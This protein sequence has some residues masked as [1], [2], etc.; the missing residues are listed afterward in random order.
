MSKALLD[1][2]KWAVEHLPPTFPSAEKKKAEDV[3][4]AFLANPKVS[5]SEIETEIVSLG[6][7]SWPH[8]KAFEIIHERYS[9][10]KEA[11]YFRGHLSMALRKKYDTFP[12]K[13]VSIHEVTRAKDFEWFFNPEEKFQLEE[14]T[15]EAHEQTI[16]DTRELIA[17]AQKGEY[18]AELAAYEERQKI[19][20][21]H[22]ETLRVLAAKSDQWAPEI[23]DKVRMFE[24]GWLALE[25]EP[26]EEI[27]IGEIDYYRNLIEGL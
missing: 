27:L 17:G 1:E 14:A 20:F 21:A 11:G 22:I 24:D 19:L 12:Q 5:E 26:N 25:R 9:K 23:M 6:R 18:A 13:G 10:E 8:R 3:L 2:L 4:A 16:R 7:A 15:F